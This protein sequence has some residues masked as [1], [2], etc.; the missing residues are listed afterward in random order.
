MELDRTL[1]ENAE[2]GR[3]KAFQQSCNSGAALE[4]GSPLTPFLRLIQNISDILHLYRFKRIQLH[5]KHMVKEVEW[6][7]TQHTG[8]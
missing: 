8:M 3:K 1:S 7:N 6:S 5:I 4:T 2:D